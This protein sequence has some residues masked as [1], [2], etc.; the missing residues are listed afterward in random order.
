LEGVKVVKFKKPFKIILAILAFILGAFGLIYLLTAT[1]WI[2]YHGQIDFGEGFTMTIAKMWANGT[3]KWDINTEPYLTLMYQPVMFLISVPLI[4]IF[5]WSISIGRIISFSASLIALGMIYYI[6]KKKTGSTILGI[7]GGLLPITITSYRDFS[8]MARPDMLSA[9]FSV[10]G[11]WIAIR[12]RNSKWFWIS[13]IAFL[14][15]FF[16]KQ[17]A[18]AGV[19]A[20]C[21]VS[22][23]KDFKRGFVYGLIFGFFVVA[24]VGIGSMLTNGEYFKHLLLYNTTSPALWDPLSIGKD[25]LWIALSTSCGVSALALLYVIK[26][27]RSKER[28]DILSIWFLMTIPIN[29]LMVFRN[30]GYVNYLM[31]YMIAGSCCAAIVLPCVIKGLISR[32]KIPLQLASAVIIVLMLFQLST[33]SGYGFSHIVPFP[34]KD[35][36]KTE[37]EV[38]E[39]IKDTNRPI[40]T[41]NAGFVTNSGKEVAIEPFVFGNLKRAGIW[42]DTG[43]IEKIDNEYYD[44]LVLRSPAHYPPRIDTGHFTL[45]W[46]DEIEKNYTVVYQSKETY[47]WY[48]MCVYKANRIMEEG[49]TYLRVANDGFVEVKDGRQVQY[50]WTH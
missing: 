35:T 7:I 14:L 37:E 46:M 1:M 4:K 41:E 21:A 42:D 24:G 38:Y 29:L 33:F 17:S 25:N 32:S 18:V 23:I 13:I 16:T 5:G 44:Y 45:K 2:P 12:W 40:V 34:D 50:T 10:I 39:I 8:F 9:M 47:F 31:E 48:T 28:L 3:W 49:E 6:V 36:I 27:I 15:A 20:V 30:G 19:V 22:I 43:F 11:I 26:V